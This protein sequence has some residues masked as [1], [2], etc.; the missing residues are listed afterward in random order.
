MASYKIIPSRRRFKA[1]L[2]FFKVVDCFA[3]QP[4][5]RLKKVGFIYEYMQQR[6]KQFYQPGQC[7]SVDEHVIQS[8]GRFIFRQYMPKK[9]V[10]WGTK[11]WALCD[12]AMS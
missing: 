7:I 10:K 2:T 11:V 6:F 3:E 5:D 9:P 12:S 4:D 1:L 8:K